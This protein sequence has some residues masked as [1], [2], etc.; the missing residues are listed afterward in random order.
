MRLFLNG[1]AQVVNRLYELLFRSARR[2]AFATS[3]DDRAAVATDPTVLRP[4]GFGEDEGLL[5]YPNRSLP[6]YRLLTEFFAFPRKFHFVDVVVPP[7]ALA[8][9]GRQLD[10]F[11]YLDRAAADLEP[12]VSADTFR[13]GCT[14]VVNLFTRRAEPIRLTHAE[15]E[16]RVVPDVR[17]PLAHEVYSVDRVTGTSPAGAEV[18]D[19]LPLYAG[20]TAASDGSRVVACA[21]GAVGWRNDRRGGDGSRDGRDCCGRGPHQPPGSARRLDRSRRDDLPEPRS[22]RPTAL[23][24]WPTPIA[25]FPGWRGRIRHPLL[26]PADAHSA[27]ETRPGYALAAGVAPDAQSPVPRGRGGRGGGAAGIR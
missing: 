2:V 26:D 6:G 14:P 9:A 23:R 22:P 25:V 4:V 21:A 5:P 15:P 10:L 11:V 7:A 8:R 17:R 19:W 27:T 16:Y 13:L 1:Q 12:Q 3:P 24:G 20:G 18:V